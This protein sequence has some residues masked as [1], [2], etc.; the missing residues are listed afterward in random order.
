MADLVVAA[1]PILEARAEDVLLVLVNG[2]PRV[3]HPE[4]GPRLGR[5]AERARRRA[6][7]P[8]VRWTDADAASEGRPLQ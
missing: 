8:V 3:A 6:V 1:K 4:L 2:E 5:F 7:G